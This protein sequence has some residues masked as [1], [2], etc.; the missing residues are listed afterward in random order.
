MIVNKKEATKLKAASYY[1]EKQNRQ[2]ISLTLR[3]KIYASLKGRK[4]R[5]L[6]FC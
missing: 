1:N 5:L 4:P 2:I 3:I 6:T